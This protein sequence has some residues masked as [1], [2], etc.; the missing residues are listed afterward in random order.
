MTAVYKFPAIALLCLLVSYSYAQ[1]DTSSQKKASLKIG[2]NYL[3]NNVYLG[4]TDT[5]STPGLSPNITYSLKSG[6]Y[7]SGSLD[8]I[9]NRKKNKL[10]GGNIEAGYN[11]TIGQN[12]EGGVSFT[13]LFYNATSTQVSSSFSSI[14]NTY[15]DYDLAG[16]ITPAMSLNYIINKS[17]ISS[18]ILLNP[19]LSHDFTIETPFSAH[20]DLQV[21]P[22]AGLNAGSQHFF[23]G[24]LQRKG[25]LNKKVASTAVTSYNNSLG[26]F[27]LLDYEISVPVEYKSGCF[28]FTF[29]PTYAF[30]QNS[31]P[32]STAAEKQ[33]TSN[34]EISSPYKPSIFYFETSIAFR[35]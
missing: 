21:S 32:Q 1:T 18:D 17:G 12:M 31:L 27:K 6:I 15:L 8:F 33:I 13:K 9:T 34:L 14:I 28:R 3:S 20:D 30:A 11:Y 10:D 7:F 16:I 25:K 26:D 5:V 4:R 29:T 23:G 24:Y 35:F 19:S 2:L 22:Q